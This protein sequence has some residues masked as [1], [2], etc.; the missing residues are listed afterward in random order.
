MLE[1]IVI[2]RLID[3][4]K[5][6]KDGSWVRLRFIEEFGEHKQFIS[7]FARGKI[8]EKAKEWG[9]GDLIYVT[10]APRATASK[11]GKNVYV[12]MV[13]S[14]SRAFRLSISNRS[15]RRGKG[16]SSKSEFE[17]AETELPDDYVP[18]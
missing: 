15:E 2:N 9:R 10:G 6:A 7:V 8:V 18:F 14:A 17:N 13:I 5:F 16:S 3:T 1:A 12:D 11:K 4:P